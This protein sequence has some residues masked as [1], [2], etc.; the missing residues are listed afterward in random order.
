MSGLAQ[1]VLRDS[2]Q[3]TTAAIPGEARI[4]GRFIRSAPGP[5]DRSRR[6][7]RRPRS[8]LRSAGTAG[9]QTRVAKRTPRAALRIAIDLVRE[10]R[11]SEDEALRRLAGLELAALAVSRFVAP[12]DPIV[13]GVAASA[14][15][16]VGH[17]A[18]DTAT[19]GMTA[20]ASL[21]ARHMGKPCVAGCEGL[22]V[23]PS[24][25][26]AGFAGQVVEEGDWI[27]IDGDSGGVFLGQREIVNERPDAELDE[28]E[29]WRASA[30]TLLLA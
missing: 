10:G 5:L 24:A 8:R 1:P 7:R 25:R 30:G 18:F 15:V 23:E 19:G 27:S 17:A 22:S 11:I 28:V 6:S 12:G 4:S 9:F 2:F 21:V 14:G 26:R 20:H 29:A 16:A 3:Q 13:R